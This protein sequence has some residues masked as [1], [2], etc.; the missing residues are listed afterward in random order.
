[1]AKLIL[2]IGLPGSGK[3]QTLK[4]FA[5]KYG[6]AFVSL[7][8]IRAEHGLGAEQESNEAVWNDVKTR[9]I[10]SF[11]SGK[12]VVLDGTFLSDSRRIALEV[13]RANGIEKIQGV[14]IDTPAEIAWERNWARERHTPDAV[15]DE[16]LAHMKAFPPKLED[17]FDSFFRLDENGE[18]VE[19]ETYVE[20]KKEPRRERRFI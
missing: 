15:F 14:F 20:T 3:S 1:M 2:A 18:L 16:R 12:S 9:T 4:R 11:K 13:A 6:Y 17:G 7:D 19:A 8:D 10:D 5:D